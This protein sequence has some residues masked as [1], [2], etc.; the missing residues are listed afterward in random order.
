MSSARRAVVSWAANSSHSLRKGAPLPPSQKGRAGHWEVGLSVPR[1]GGGAGPPVQGCDLEQRQC[2][3]NL[4]PSTSSPHLRPVAV[5][6]WTSPMP[7]S[8][9]LGSKPRGTW[10]PGPLPKA[11]HW[12]LDL[13]ELPGEP[14]W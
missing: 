3:N 10:G 6:A 11:P 7:R 4:A 14:G 12:S 2:G 9:G 1:G 5:T 13:L 8:Q